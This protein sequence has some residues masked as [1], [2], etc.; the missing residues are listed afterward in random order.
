M[1]FKTRTGDPSWN[2]AF[3][4]LNKTGNLFTFNN[5]VFVTEDPEVIDFLKAKCYDEKL[6][7]NGHIEFYEEPKEVKK[8]KE[9]KEVKN[10][11]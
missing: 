8:V 5:G 10:E 2:N 1:I 4:K 9:P 3:F 7:P 11:I 6:N